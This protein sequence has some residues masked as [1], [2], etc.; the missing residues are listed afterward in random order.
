MYLCQAWKLYEKKIHRTLIDESLDLNQSQEEHVMKITEIALLCTQSP[1]SNRPTMSEVVL[2]L[3]ED[4]SLGKRQLTRP[5]F[6]HNQDR[7]IHILGS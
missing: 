2:M 1:A 7:R 6:I 3:Q 5:T 4:Q